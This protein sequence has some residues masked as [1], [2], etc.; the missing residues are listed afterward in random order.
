VAEHRK[1]EILELARAPFTP[2][3][4]G[5]EGDPVV[6]GAQIGEPDISTRATP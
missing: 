3:E 4:I 2:A 1:R 6:I 5:V